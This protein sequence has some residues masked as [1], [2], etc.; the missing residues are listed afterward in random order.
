[1]DGEGRAMS[2]TI[3]ELTDLNLWMPVMTCSE[4]LKVGLVNYSQPMN[5]F[6]SHR[7]LTNIRYKIAAIFCAKLRLLIE[8]MKIHKNILQIIFLSSNPLLHAN[9]SL[10]SDACKQFNHAE[11]LS[12]A[13]INHCLVAAK[14]GDGQSQ[15]ILGKL[16]FLGM[17]LEKNESLGVKFWI[18]A[19]NKG[20]REAQ[21]NLGWLHLTG[22]IVQKNYKQAFSWYLKA[23]LQGDPF[24]GHFLGLMFQNGFGVP[25]D[26]DK[27]IK[28]YKKSASLGLIDSQYNLA[29][30]Y[31]TS[32]SISTNAA[33]SYARMLV[34]AKMNY[35]SAIIDIPS[36]EKEF[37][38]EDKQKG[39][40]LAQR[41]ERDLQ[42]ATR[43]ELS[44]LHTEFG[45]EKN[46][47]LTNPFELISLLN[48]R[49][50][51]ASDHNSQQQLLSELYLDIALS[52]ASS[53]EHKS[54][55]RIV[56]NME[57]KFDSNNSPTTDTIA[58]YV[59]EN[60]ETRSFYVDKFVVHSK[61]EE[62]FLRLNHLSK[63]NRDASW[64]VCEFILD[65]NGAYQIKYTDNGAK[66][67][68][69]IY[70]EESFY[71]YANEY[72]NQYIREAIIYR[73]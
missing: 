7:S 49:K 73:N 61:T 14:Q 63:E 51:L 15:Y 50:N 4:D 3:A 58:I 19:A 60:M 10:H 53:L 71:K 21:R 45:Y 33:K 70:D 67:L 2:G 47:F 13:F 62:S 1:M 56:V 64:D 72:L 27:A 59:G 32:N 18:N 16:A 23:A 29:V 40:S 25:T 66:R 46:P 65:N 39:H 36:L 69:G 52:V 37:S 57:L 20:V 9:A 35:K 17:G 68:K 44:Y 42:Q 54:W 5:Y 38:A 48:F 43:T 6:T 22:R 34:A 12:P 24:S 28:W 31:Y 41:I 11:D 55:Q 30:M 26:Y 8:A